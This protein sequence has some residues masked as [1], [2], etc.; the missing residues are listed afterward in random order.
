MA[1]ETSQHGTPA[2]TVRVGPP[3]VPA[4]DENPVVEASQRSRET[5]EELETELA[6]QLYWKR[7]RE[8]ERREARLAMEKAQLALD[9]SH[10]DTGRD[11]DKRIGNLMTRVDQMRR[12][13]QQ[14]GSVG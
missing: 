10:L 5:L 6:W 12:D 11:S 3:S 9:R 13:R 1:G 2:D 4:S 8:L 14:L 7:E